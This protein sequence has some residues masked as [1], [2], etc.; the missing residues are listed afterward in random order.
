MSKLLEV[1]RCAG[2][3]QWLVNPGLL[4]IVCGLL[5]VLHWNTLER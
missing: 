2:V 1:S 5:L 3:L 4:W